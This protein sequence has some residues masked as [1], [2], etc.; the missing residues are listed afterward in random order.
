MLDVP[1]EEYVDGISSAALAA[2]WRGAVTVRRGSQPTPAAAPATPYVGLVPYTRGRRA[3][4]LRPR[5]RSGDHRRQPARVAADAALRRRAASARARSCG[6]ASSTTCASRPSE[7]SLTLGHAA[8]SRVVRRSAPGATTRS[9][10]A[11]SRPSRSARDRADRRSRRRGDLV[12]D[13]RRSTSARRDALRR[14]P[15]RRATLLVVLDQFEE[16]FL[17]HPDEDG[18]GTLRR[19]VPARVNAP[20][21]RVEL[22]ALDPRGRLREARPLQGPDPAPL[23]ELPPGRPPRPRGRAARRSR[24]RSSRVQ[25]SCSRRRR[26]YAV[27]PELVE[28]VL[29]AGASRARRRSARPAAGIG[30]ARRADAT[31]GRDAVPPARHGAALGG[32]ARGGLAR[33]CTLATLEQ[34]GGAERIVEQPPRRGARRARRRA[35]RTSRPTS[36]AT[37]SRRRGRRSSHAVPTSPSW[38]QAC[39]SRR[40][41]AVLEKLCR[42]DARILRPVDAAAGRERGPRYEIFH[43]V[44]ASRSSTGAPRTSATGPR[45][46]RLPGYGGCGGGSRRAGA[47]WCCSSSSSPVSRSGRSSNSGRREGRRR[48]RVPKRSRRPPCRSSTPIPSSAPAG[49]GGRG[50]ERH[51]GGRGRLTPRVDGVAPAGRRAGPRPG[52][53]RRNLARRQPS[54]HRRWS[55]DAHLRRATG[56]GA[57]YASFGAGLVN[58]AAFDRKGRLI[59]TANTDGTARILDAQGAREQLVIRAGSA[60]VVAAR[61]PRRTPVLT[62]SRD[63]A[64][65]I[66][67]ARTGDPGALLRVRPPLRW[68]LVSPGGEAVLIIG[69]ARRRARLALAGPRGREAPSTC[70][71]SWARTAVSALADDGR[72]ASGGPV[73][74]VPGRRRKRSQARCASSTP[75]R[76][77]ANDLRSWRRERHRLQPSRPA[78][79]DGGRRRPASGTRAG[80]A[81]VV[82]YPFSEV[83]RTCG[84]SRS[85]PTAETL[86]TTSDDGSARLW[87]AATGEQLAVF[88]SPPGPT[89][90]AFSPSGKLVGRRAGDVRVWRRMRCRRASRDGFPVCRSRPSRD[91]LRARRIAP[92]CRGCGRVDARN[93]LRRI[94]HAFLPTALPGSIFSVSPDG[95]L[96]AYGRGVRMRRRADGDGGCGCDRPRSAG[97]RPGWR[98]WT[99]TGV[100]E[101][102]RPARVRPAPSVEPTDTRWGSLPAAEW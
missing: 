96:V 99:A 100:W 35:S 76:P 14:G 15:A 80:D 50:R 101:C 37:S 88:R 7:R 45:A 3:V 23:R 93:R 82:R 66:F 31:P 42:G 1:L 64:A 67:D 26:P 19:R 20:N 81:S 84:R 18:E 63:G 21:L 54:A 85:P 58:E 6:P 87:R 5:A 53:Q 98:S 27:E 40:L 79:G 51:Q 91:H 39:P 83:L 86:L 28:A 30:R 41:R 74:L 75:E 49:V 17:Y 65:R 68:Y 16:Y 22:P 25:P 78:C 29:D 24:G 73:S 61:S 92:G 33:R 34:L 4:L 48:W 94:R 55:P 11:D 44:L 2:S 62:V 46:P 97:T 38:T 90:G 69:R 9:P 59:V 102:G 52:A 71:A 77:S 60:A 56:G 89:R 95:R 10:V 47:E 72:V 70:R 43:D 57:D 13:G 8:R 36:S 32:G 12:A